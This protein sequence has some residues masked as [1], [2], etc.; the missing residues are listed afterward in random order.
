M[1]KIQRRY[2]INF[3]LKIPSYIWQKPCQN[4]LI[5]TPKFQF[6]K[7]DFVFHIL[8]NCRS[9]RPRWLRRGSAVARLLRLWVRV[10]PTAWIFVWC[11]CC[12]L[13]GRGLCDEPIAH[14]EKSY[15]LWCVAVCDLETSSMR[16]PWPALGCSATGKKK[17][18]V[19]IIILKIS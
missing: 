18:C 13:S 7:S 4:L 10:P 15:Q 5:G 12:V 3:T 16:R 17:Y 8:F 11:E 2:Y 6:D 14:P 9:Q 19:L 1:C